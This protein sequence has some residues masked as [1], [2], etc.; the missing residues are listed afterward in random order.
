MPQTM[1]SGQLG[2]MAPLN[3]EFEIRQGS[4]AA[5]AI[6]ISMA[7]GASTTAGSALVVQ[8]QGS[9]VVGSSIGGFPI[10][11]AEYDGVWGL[12]KV[13]NLSTASTGI[14]LAASQSGGFCIS[15]DCTAGAQ[16]I[17]LPAMAAGLNYEVMVGGAVAASGLTIAAATAGTIVTYG[18]AAANSIEIGETTGT[19]I[20]G[21][22]RFISDGTKWYS[23]TQPS[24]TSAAAATNTMTLYTIT[25]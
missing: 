12:R 17:T 14:T 5:D 9:T 8:R 13:Y 10:F 21:S 2:N 20:G 7:S 23:I 16:T 4:T 24:L 11:R 25:T 6:T 3:G 22:V 18:D 1:Q 19:A 15:G